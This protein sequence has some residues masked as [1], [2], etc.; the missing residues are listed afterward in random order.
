[1]QNGQENF[2]GFSCDSN[3]NIQK[4]RLVSEFQGLNIVKNDSF[5]SICFLLTSY[6]LYLKLKD[7]LV[8]LWNVPFYPMYVYFIVKICIYFYLIVK[9]DRDFAGDFDAKENIGGLL[10]VRE[11]RNL[12]LISNLYHFFVCLLWVAFIY[13][14]HSFLDN[15]EKDECLHNACKLLVYISIFFKKR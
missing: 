5:F 12:Y 13:K 6:F 11:V 7:K 1:M 4:I 10:A 3:K 8:V 9:N 15:R 14:V 2:P